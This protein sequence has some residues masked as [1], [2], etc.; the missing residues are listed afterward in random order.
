MANT[1]KENISTNNNNNS[2]IKIKLNYNNSVYDIPISTEINSKALREYIF[3]KFNL[4]NNYKLLYKCK[5]IN[6][7][8]SVPLK[9]L[10]KNDSNPI[11]FIND[12]NTILP[13]IKPSS[14]ITIATNLP[15]QRILN[16]LN[17]FFQS[18]YLQLDA[19]IRIP[20]K[21]VYNIKFSKPYLAKEFLNYYN[22]KLYRK[23]NYDNTKLITVNCNTPKNINFLKNIP[24]EKKP[25]SNNENILCKLTEKNIKKSCSMSKIVKYNNRDISLLKVIKNNSKSDLLSQQFISAGINKY[26]KSYK[27]I[28]TDK[29]N[30]NLKSKSSLSDSYESAYKFPYMSQEE[31]YNIERYLDKKNWISKKAF[32]VSVGKYK[33]KDNFIPNY[34]GATPSESPLMHKFREI[35]KKK[36]IKK[37]G[38][39]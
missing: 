38:F 5:I 3:S 1:N 26:H 18:K 2:T 30:R 7:K 23:V 34:V 19:F 37:I 28:S 22:N 27:E 33:I 13:S 9:I 17:S 20:M 39:L 12:N 25:T 15:Q 31:K 11:L 14:T 29:S 24:I 8:E 35:N 4:D 10:F 21:G 36:W 16:L 32:L 6:D